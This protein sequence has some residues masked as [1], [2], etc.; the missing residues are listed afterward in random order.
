MPEAVLVYIVWKINDLSFPRLMSG[1]HNN[2][3]QRQA[4]TG[5]VHF[6]HSSLRH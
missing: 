6:M 5:G 3:N 2:G 1:K 4:E